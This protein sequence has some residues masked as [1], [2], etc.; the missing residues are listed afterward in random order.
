MRT[1][2]DFQTFHRWLDERN[3]FS[4]DIPLNMMLL[5]GEVG[6]VVQVIKKVHF[7]MSRNDG[8]SVTLED[9]LATHRASIGEELADCLAYVFKIANYTG[10]DLQKAYIEKM[11]QN[12]DRTWKHES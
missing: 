12:L 6:E 2:G 5:S 11:E 9:A 1:I 4:T 7:M 8:E 10:V 3:N